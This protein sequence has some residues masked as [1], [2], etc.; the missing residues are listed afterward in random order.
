MTPVIFCYWFYQFF[1][2]SKHQFDGTQLHGKVSLHTGEQHNKTI[3]LVMAFFPSTILPNQQKTDRS[4]TPKTFEM[5]YHCFQAIPFLRI[6]SGRPHSAFIT[7]LSVFV[8][9][10]WVWFHSLNNSGFRCICY[11][12]LYSAEHAEYAFFVRASVRLF[13]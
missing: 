7:D 5:I 9:L 11:A 13:W 6:P 12:I 2:M 10:A 1:W 8:F 3:F 4:T